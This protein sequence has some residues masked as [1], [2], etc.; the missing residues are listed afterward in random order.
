[1][2]ERDSG[3]RA[4]LRTGLANNWRIVAP[5]GSKVSGGQK[6]QRGVNEARIDSSATDMLLPDPDEE[7]ALICQGSCITRS[8]T[9]VDGE[10]GG[11]VQASET[12]Q[13]LSRPEPLQ[14]QEEHQHQEE[15]EQPPSQH[16]PALSHRLSLILDQMRAPSV[17]LPPSH[18]E[19]AQPTASPKAHH[20][21]PLSTSPTP[22]KA[23]QRGQHAISGASQ[24]L[25]PQHLAFDSLAPSPH[26]SHR[27]YSAG[28]G[29]QPAAQ[30]RGTAQHSHQP[31]STHEERLQL[32]SWT[33]RRPTASGAAAH[34]LPLPSTTL[35]ADA[36]SQRS[37]RY[38]P[39]P[40][41][42]PNHLPPAAAPRSVWP[43]AV[44]SEFTFRPST[45][46]SDRTGMAMGPQ[47]S[48]SQ[49][50]WLQ[51]QQQQ[52]PSVFLHRVSDLHLDTR[53][54]HISSSGGGS[55]A[56]LYP[57]PL[58]PPPPQQQQP[59]Q[60]QQSSQLLSR[61]ITSMLLEGGC[62]H[63]D[64]CINVR[65]ADACVVAADLCVSSELVL[66]CKLS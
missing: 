36:G 66:P 34:P 21:G 25:Q 6:K 29:A 42:A 11:P 46:S 44:A 12:L 8:S 28:P 55:H 35:T 52:Q 65:G 49:Q 60:Q 64:M 7:A 33:R 2:R 62:V 41:P 26:T 3:A 13:P 51:Q 43:P 54:L 24:E 10:D 20:S 48:S 59:Q 50:L 58:S 4:P 23:G 18:L 22:R 39:P 61:N 27:R 1:M 15:Q 38:L 47:Q 45:S 9:E 32:L 5:P 19:A 57:P 30:H 40:P 17:Q 56:V 14:P 63:A 16:E 31:A 37:R 53:S